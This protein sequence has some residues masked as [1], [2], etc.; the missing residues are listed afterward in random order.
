M[1]INT[2]FDVLKNW[3]K[4]F[5]ILLD[6]NIF[7]TV[8]QRVTVTSS[9][10]RTPEDGGVRYTALL[11][12]QSPVRIINLSFLSVYYND[13]YQALFNYVFRE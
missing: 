13:L 6:L 12:A 3:E 4:L 5:D 8:E 7:P 9:L 1:S 11:T 2:S 10:V